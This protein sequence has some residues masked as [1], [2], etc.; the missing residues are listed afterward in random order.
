MTVVIPIVKGLVYSS[1]SKN[2][3]L[4]GI[5]KP[6]LMSYIWKA[7]VSLIYRLDKIPNPCLSRYLLNICRMTN[8]SMDYFIATIMPAFPNI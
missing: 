2:G 3:C 4:I 7:N 8:G 1:G 5:S 6:K